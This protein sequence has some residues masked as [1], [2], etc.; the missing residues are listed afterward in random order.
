[1]Q[2]VVMPF[3]LAKD[4]KTKAES[5][6]TFTVQSQR[7]SFRSVSIIGLRF[8]K[9]YEQERYN[10]GGYPF[11][12]AWDEY[13]D[14]LELQR[15]NISI[16]NITANNLIM[17]INRTPELKALDEIPHWIEFS[18]EQASPIDQSAIAIE[19]RGQLEYQT[20]DTKKARLSENHGKL[21]SMLVMGTNV[22][23]GE[24]GGWEGT[25]SCDMR[26]IGAF[27]LRNEGHG[28]TFTLKASMYDFKHSGL[29]IM[30]EM[31]VELL[32]R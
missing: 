26:N 6:I 28:N 12:Q 30:P 29:S 8:M 7:S 20:T 27:R 25:V 16:G 23:H 3:K 4:D 14:Y 19:S 32:F 2:H 18:L 13:K 10:I 1:M 11:T 22:I 9:V 17:G 31:Q 24:G 5:E 15:E 21:Q